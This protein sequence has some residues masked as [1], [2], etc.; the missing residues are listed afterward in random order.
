MRQLSEQT[1]SRPPASQPFA[2]QQESAGAVPASQVHR[3]AA[4]PVL[5]LRRLPLRYARQLV[6][7]IRL[8]RRLVDRRTPAGGQRRVASTLLS[9]KRC[10]LRLVE[11]RC[12]VAL[13]LLVARL[14]LLLLV[15]LVLL[16]LLHLLLPVLLPLVPLVVVVLLLLLL[17]Q[18]LLLLL[19][20]GASLLPH[21][22]DLALRV[23]LVEAELRALEQRPLLAKVFAAQPLPRRPG[24]GPPA[25]ERL[26][27][28]DKK[29]K[30]GGRI[31]ALPRVDCF[32]SFCL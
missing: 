2:A 22:K 24:R 11:C 30:C 13:G 23:A 9:A 18:L 6:V 8:A 27:H 17:L 20:C 29:E 12:G 28:L 31:N 7:V 25:G 3:V 5:G 19:V 15:L 1:E 4:V 26:A 14:V 16:V 21:G 32:L 10:W